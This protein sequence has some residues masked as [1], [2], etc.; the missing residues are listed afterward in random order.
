MRTLQLLLI[1]LLIPMT[2][3]AQWVYD[4]Q[5]DEMTDEVT[6]TAAI[7][8]PDKTHA[9]ALYKDDKGIIL[10][11]RIL[12]TGSV[13]KSCQGCTI[14]IRFDADLAQDVLIFTGDDHKTFI[15]MAS[16]TSTHHTLKSPIIQR[17]LKAKTLKVAVPLIGEPPQ[18]V[19]FNLNGLDPKRLYPQP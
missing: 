15:I 19:T 1:L 6:N 9:V 5:K 8:A 4:Q 10:G 3:H 7:L 14:K 11:V 16:K 2:V 17:L 18:V 12:T 13:L